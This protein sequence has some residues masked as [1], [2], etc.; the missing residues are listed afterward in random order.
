MARLPRLTV[1]GQA[2]WI[3]QRGHSGRTVFADAA[4][5]ATFARLLQAAAAAE[6]VRLHAFSL[7]DTEVQLLATPQDG[8]SLS[9]LMQSLGRGYVSAHHRRHGG[10]GTLWDGRFRCAVVEPGGTLLDVLCLID[11][12]AIAHG[13]VWCEARRGGAGAAGAAAL[14]DPVEYWQLGNT[15]FARQAAWQRRLEQGL[16]EQRS[17]TL[18]QAALGGW[19]VGSAAF[20]SLIG[21]AAA[22][23]MAPRPPGRPR[24]A[25]AV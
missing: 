12:R 19:V 18:Q 9:R 4:D 5:R 10:S 14:A 24:R 15:P 8:P 13:A 22:R 11:T 23:P 3:I 16:D 25:A 20:A 2:H 1:P 7:A 6:Q 21:S 17:R